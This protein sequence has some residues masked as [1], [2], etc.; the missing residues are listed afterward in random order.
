MPSNQVMKTL[1]YNPDIP[2]TETATAVARHSGTELYKRYQYTQNLLQNKYHSFIMNRNQ[3]EIL[4]KLRELLKT[5]KLTEFDFARLIGRIEKWNSLKI[6]FPALYLDIL[7]IS[8]DELQL[9]LRADLNAFHRAMQQNWI[10]DSFLVD[11]PSGSV[12]IALPQGLPETDA[13]K[14]ARNW[15]LK[16]PYRAKYITVKELR[17]TVI[18]PDG[19]TYVLSYPPVLS[20]RKGIYI[21][22]QTGE[23]QNGLKI[24]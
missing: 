12:R 8:H 15:Q 14:V 19:H 23:C 10:A 24:P 6:S 5:Q 3:T 22:S 11:L 18:Q 20:L 21:P 16:T 13:V 7:G 4:Q 1:P 17:T 9:A 2:A